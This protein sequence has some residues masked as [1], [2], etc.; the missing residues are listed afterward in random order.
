MEEWVTGMT[1]TLDNAI[2]TEAGLDLNQRQIKVK[3]R[4]RLP[5]KV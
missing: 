5:P 1:V 2:P 3:E 4:T